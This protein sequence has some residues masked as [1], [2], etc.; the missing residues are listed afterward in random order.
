M[1][2]FESPV[3]KKRKVLPTIVCKEDFLSVWEFHE[4]LK[5]KG[6]TQPDQKFNVKLKIGKKKKFKSFRFVSYDDTGGCSCCGTRYQITLK[7]GN[8]MISACNMHFPYS[9][10]PELAKI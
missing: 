1:S 4:M 6:I 9:I 2:T 3:K 10:V 8:K 5:A 7:K